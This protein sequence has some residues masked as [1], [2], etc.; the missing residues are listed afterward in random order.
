VIHLFNYLYVIKNQWCCQVSIFLKRSKSRL[1]INDSSIS[2]KNEHQHR[3]I[4][5][6]PNVASVSDRSIQYTAEFK[7]KVVQENLAGKGPA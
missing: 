1:F 2:S 3:Q 6:N 4:E 5:T 7:F